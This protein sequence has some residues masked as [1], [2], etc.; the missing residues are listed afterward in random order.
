M[1]C[2]PTTTLKEKYVKRG[3]WFYFIFSLGV[4]NVD[5]EFLL[6]RMVGGHSAIKLEH[7]EMREKE[8]HGSL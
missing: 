1:V 7:Y 2:Y 4:L 3:K 8:K 6:G 5:I